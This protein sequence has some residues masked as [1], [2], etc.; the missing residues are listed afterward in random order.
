MVFCDV[1]D[2]FSERQKR[3]TSSFPTEKTVCLRQSSFPTGETVLLKNIATVCHRQSG[4][5]EATEHDWIVK[6]DLKKCVTAKKDIKKLY[7]PIHLLNN[8]RCIEYHVNGVTY[9]NVLTRFLDYF[10]S[11]ILRKDDDSFVDVFSW[12]CERIPVSSVLNDR[13]QLIFTYNSN[14]KP[15]ISESHVRIQATEEIPDFSNPQTIEMFQ[16]FIVPY[17]ELESVNNKLRKFEEIETYVFNTGI[18]YLII[19]K[20]E[21]RV[22]SGLVGSKYCL[23]DLR[24][25]T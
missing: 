20:N 5:C 19:I 17:T 2:L 1:K 25:C 4:F 7:I 21:L 6:L 10:H 18:D 22:L 15:H 14:K 9:F 23:V 3:Q 12:C 13:P 16:S 24:Q 8:L 11:N